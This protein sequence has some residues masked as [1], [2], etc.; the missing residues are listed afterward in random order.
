MSTQDRPQWKPGTKVRLKSGSPD[1]TVQQQ[2]VAAFG[3]GEIVICKWVDKDGRP[4]KDH[5]APESLAS[6]D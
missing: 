2:Y 4:Q 6:V 1:M 3:V 5:F